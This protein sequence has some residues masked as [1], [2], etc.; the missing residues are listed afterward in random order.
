MSKSVKIVAP[1]VVIPETDSNI[2]SIKL[3][4]ENKNGIAAINPNNTQANDATTNASERLISFNSSSFDLFLS[5]LY[6]ISP[7]AKAIIPAAKNARA[8]FH[9]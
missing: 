7:N 4:P 9:S 6:A 2:E 8:E 1:V 5:V 3:K